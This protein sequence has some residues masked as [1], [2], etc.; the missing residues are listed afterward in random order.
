MSRICQ[1]VDE[2]VAGSDNYPGRS[3]AWTRAGILEA[4][5]KLLE[6][7]N[8]LFDDM[9]KKLSDVKGLDQMIRSVLFQGKKISYNPDDDATR[10]GSMFGYLKKKEGVSLLATG[11]LRRGYITV[12]FQKTS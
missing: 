4:V 11:Y 8:T 12:I 6:E 7:Q 9:G 2:R 5:K 3:A 1:L 10:L